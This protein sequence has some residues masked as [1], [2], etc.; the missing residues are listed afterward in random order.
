MA[1]AGKNTEIFLAVLRAEFTVWTF[2][3]VSRAI[4]LVGIGIFGPYCVM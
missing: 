3:A 1:M 4:L 2:L